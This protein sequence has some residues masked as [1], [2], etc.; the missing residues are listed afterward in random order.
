MR[1]LPLYSNRSNCLFSIALLSRWSSSGLTAIQ[2]TSSFRHVVLPRTRRNQRCIH[3]LE[4][5]L[6]LLRIRREISLRG[7]Q[8]TLVIALGKVWFVVRPTRFVAQARPLSHHP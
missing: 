4:F 7:L 2:F 8:E 5:K 3:R 6:R 1:S